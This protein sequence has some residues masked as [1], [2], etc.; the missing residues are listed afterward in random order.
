V[1][2]RNVDQLLG[3]PAIV[4][5]LEVE[6]GERVVAMGVEAGETKT[7]CGAKRSSAGIHT[8]STAARKPR[9]SVIAGS[10]TFTMWSLPESA[11]L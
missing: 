9:P 11:P 10:G 6:V 3:D 4:L 2:V 8:R 7:N 1:A 5:V